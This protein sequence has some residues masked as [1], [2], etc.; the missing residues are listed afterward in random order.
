M[1]LGEL[2]NE[3]KLLDMYI[4]NGEIIDQE[5]VTIKSIPEIVNGDLELEAF[6]RLLLKVDPTSRPSAE[7][8]LA[9]PYLSHCN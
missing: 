6:L 4:C 5:E 3:G 2:P 1:C 8:A 7:E 9:H